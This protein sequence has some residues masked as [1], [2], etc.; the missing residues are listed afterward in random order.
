[1]L[2]VA[3]AELLVKQHLSDTPRADHSRFVAH[4]MRA[5]APRFSA[6]TDL[7]EVVGLCHDLDYFYTHGNWSQH[8]LVT[9]AW[10]GDKIPA[11]AQHAIAA[12]DHRTGV[13]ADTLLADMLKAADALA[14]IDEKLGRTS[15]RNADRTAPY[16]ALRRLL[17]D[18]S[19][20]SDI[21][22]RY[23]NRHGVPFEDLIDVVAR[24]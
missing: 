8:G 13:Q 15:L 23:A 21:L 7:W 1:M 17:G 18:R 14:I 5:L 24:A 2:N 19:Y 16:P 22:E 10:L 4:I 6:S 9:V 20:L 3:D 12:H 11:E